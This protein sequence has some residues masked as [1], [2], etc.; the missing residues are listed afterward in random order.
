MVVGDAGILSACHK[1]VARRIALG[2]ALVAH[3]PEAVVEKCTLEVLGGGT[4]LL[5][6]CKF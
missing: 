6:V 1:A 2:T 4:A 5:A 3:T